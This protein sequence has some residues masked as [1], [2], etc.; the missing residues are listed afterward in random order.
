MRRCIATG[1]ELTLP[2]VHRLIDELSK[3]PPLEAEQQKN[4]GPPSQN[5][6]D[7]LRPVAH[8]SFSLPPPDQHGLDG[9]ITPASLLKA[10]TVYGAVK[11]VQ[12]MS[13][14]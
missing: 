13:T 11:K 5:R 3:T 10:F 12:V 4:V 6:L 7:V 14:W 2:D 8:L 1:R 9:E